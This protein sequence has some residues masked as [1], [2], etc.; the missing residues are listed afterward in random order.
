M[1]YCSK[2]EMKKTGMKAV[3]KCPRKSNGFDKGLEP[4]KI[5]GVTDRSGELMF[6]ISWKVILMTHPFF[7]V[8]KISISGQRRG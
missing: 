4:D 5:V 8:G 7:V 3:R 6:L 2:R 1:E